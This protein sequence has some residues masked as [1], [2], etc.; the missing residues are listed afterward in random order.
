MLDWSNTDRIQKIGIKKAKKIKS[1]YVFI[2]PI[3]PANSKSIW[4]NCAKVLVDKSNE[5][6]QPYLIKLFE[7]LKDMN[8]PGADLIFD[9]LILIPKELILPAYKHCVS[10]AEKTDDFAWSLSLKHFNEQYILNRKETS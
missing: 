9:R 1:V 10:L 5:E 8:W 3:L 7:W 4:E 6:L 2:L